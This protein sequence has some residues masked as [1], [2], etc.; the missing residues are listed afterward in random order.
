MESYIGWVGA[1]NGLSDELVALSKDD[2]TNGTDALRQK[3][4]ELSE[5]VVQLEGTRCNN[6]LAKARDCLAGWRFQLTDKLKTEFMDIAHKLGVPYTTMDQANKGAEA[7]DEP[8]TLTLWQGFENTFERLMS[9][10]PESSSESGTR[11]GAAAVTA[12]LAE[13]LRL[14]FVPL[15]VRFATHFEQ[16]TELNNNR[17]IKPSFMFRCVREWIDCNRHL[18]TERLGKVLRGAGFKSFD[19]YVELIKGFAV[20]LRCKLT[21]DLATLRT[22]DKDA[23]LLCV[24][25]RE[26]LRFDRDTCELYGITE[27]EAMISGVV[28]RDDV[29]L[30]RWLNTEHRI[31]GESL[32]EVCP[33]L[34]ADVEDAFE[35]QE[36]W[37][38]AF[39][40]LGVFDD[41]NIP[42]SADGVVTLFESIVTLAQL[43]PDITLQ[44]RVVRENQLRMLELY[45]EALVARCSFSNRILHSRMPLNPASARLKRASV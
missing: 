10:E 3:L 1:I 44:E 8:A 24:T 19:P 30:E 32:D 28:L 7:A 6:L 41:A 27:T 36:Q 22:G 39:G 4:Q 5:L 42:S 9:F 45:R 29:Y 38:P 15:F 13:P 16:C 20:L 26:M 37:E 31:I 21:Y 43:V 14:L 33:C 25:T 34:R 40:V 35:Q 23:T 18:F 17:N 2:T 11:H 12:G